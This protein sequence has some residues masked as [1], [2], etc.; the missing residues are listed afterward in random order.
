M[1][2]ASGFASGAVSGSGGPRLPTLTDLLYQLASGS[3]TSVEL[4]RRSLHEIE[5]SQ[6]TLNAFRV[7]L[8]ES[9]LADA[10]AADRR[11]A[12][13]DA[14]P[15]LGIPIA[16]KDDVDVAGVPTAFGTQGY[17]R[18][19]AHDSEVVRRLKAAGAVI[20]G[21]TNTCELGQ[22]PFTSGPGFGH[23]RNPWARRHTPGGS[24]GGSAAAV[25]AGLVTAAIGSDGAG[26]IRVPAAW[27]HLVGI[28]PQR[29]R[30]S[31]WPWPETFNGITVN[32]VLA[33]TVAD[34][35]LVLDA[36]SGN[37][38]GD[39]HKPAPLTASDYVG[40]APGPL[41]IAMSTRFPYTGFRAKL[42]PEIL[43][44]TRRVGEQ[45]QL[46]GHTVER[47]NPDYG[48][49]LSWDF[50]AR[51]TAGLWEWAECLG[52]GV[53]LDPRT[54]TNMRA[55]HALSQAI[56]RNARHHEAAAQRRVGSIFDIVDVVLAPTTAQPPPL[57]RAFDD[58]GGLATDRA[59]IA[60]CPLTW[61]WNLLGWPSIN[62]PAGFTV[63]GLPIGVQLMG[64]AESEGLL[65]SLAAELE[66]V[67]G[68]ATKQPKV[69]WNTG[70]STPPIHSVRPPRR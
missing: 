33:R 65:I 52:N 44:A 36:A 15:L 69:W 34:A 18:P 28:K 5:V 17:V 58:M 59:I 60:A 19:A 37:V 42:H 39:L 68:W 12:A 3:V 56:L 30:I 55:G 50:L 67:S 61:P 62:V 2:G 1:V 54:V 51:S 64:P 10:A 32:G 40:I 26:S 43:A 45:L 57:A 4:T 20:I 49:R 8:T 53:T 11:R 14:A 16:V 22:W 46:L 13:G 29:G 24:S 7:V 48:L 25:A 38:E 35:A 6:S 27:T 9:A 23:T 21:K 47:G 66:A 70:T 41:K 31:T 63:D